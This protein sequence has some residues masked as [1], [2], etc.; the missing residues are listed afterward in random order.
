MRRRHFYITQLAGADTTPVDPNAASYFEVV[1]SAASAFTGDALTATVTAKR[2]N[3][4]TDTNYVGTV[5]LS[6]TDPLIV[7][8]PA[9]YTFL[10]G[11]NGVKVFAGIEYGTAGTQNFKAQTGSKTGQDTLEI[12]APLAN[13]NALE[14]DGVDDVMTIPNSPELD[15][16][17]S[18]SFS[19]ST[20]LDMSAVPNGSAWIYTDVDLSAF[21]VNVHGKYFQVSLDD[22][23]GVKYL[24]VS[25]GLITAYDEI[26]PEEIGVTT[27]FSLNW[28]SLAGWY[29]VGMSYDGSGAGAGVKIYIN[30]V[31]AA[32]TIETDTLNQA[33]SI[34]TGLP[35]N[36]GSKPELGAFIEIKMDE[37]CF[38]SSALSGANFA[39]IYAAG[40]ITDMN[41]TGLPLISW[42]RAD[43][44]VS[45]TVLDQSDAGYNNDATLVNGVVIG[46]DTP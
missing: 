1:L 15:F 12:Y 19:F 3:G 8:L 22:Q 45:P 29:H 40:N 17:W 28:P 39:Q 11:D 27:D 13:V 46:V 26:T 9:P 24:R 44:D 30:G 41:A 20:W 7:N 18:D 14:F 10:V 42:Y 35:I 33:V 5:T 4:D 38:W 21:P 6:S 2:P 37:I 43:G 32:S 34:Q 25:V 16:E 31:Q 23:G 36:I